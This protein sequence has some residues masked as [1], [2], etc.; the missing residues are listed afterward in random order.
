MA[1]LRVRWGEIQYDI[2]DG[3]RPSATGGSRADQGVG[4]TT[5]RRDPL[6]T[7]AAGVLVGGVEETAVLFVAQDLHWIHS[8][9]ANRWNDRRQSG[10]E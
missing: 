6:R 4:P 8:C 2:T 9:C 5:E 3:P 7:V 1:A 10:D